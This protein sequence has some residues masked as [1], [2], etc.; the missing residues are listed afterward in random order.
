MPQSFE[1]QFKMTDRSPWT[2]GGMFGTDEEA[3]DR[4]RRLYSS[5]A[6]EIRVL[7]HTPRVVF[8][9]VRKG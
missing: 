4:C 5:G 7:D 1:A 6:H 3:K 9:Y 2:F 8:E